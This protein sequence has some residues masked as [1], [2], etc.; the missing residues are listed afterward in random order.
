MFT[1]AITDFTP[2]G[3]DF[4]NN[5]S[6][7][8]FREGYSD[9]DVTM[10]TVARAL[11]SRRL[12]EEEKFN[13]SLFDVNYNKTDDI[14]DVVLLYTLRAGSQTPE[15]LKNKIL[16]LNLNT[17]GS[18]EAKEII[19]KFESEWI[20][21]HDTFK[22]HKKADAFLSNYLVC[23]VM[24]NEANRSAI[25]VTEK[26]NMPKWHV[27][28]SMIPAYVPD[29]FKGEFALTDEEK[30]MA[31][32]LTSRNVAS[33]LEKLSALEKNYNIR[34][35]RIQ[36][37]IGGFEKKQRQI[38]K[39]QIEET[40]EDLRNKMEN[41]IQRYNEL[42]QRYDD[43]N[44][45]RN[46]L[47]Y[48]IDNM[49]DN[50]DLVKFFQAN[51]CLDVV[52]TYGSSISFI[53]RTYYENFDVD[54]YENYRNNDNFLSESRPRTGVFTE[55]ENRK[56]IMDAMFITQQIKLKICAL[57]EL[58]IRGRL[59]TTTSYSFPT[60]CEDYI[61]NYHI[62]HHHCFGNYER[63]ILGYLNRGDTIGAINACIASAKSVNIAESGPTFNPMMAQ[64][65]ASQKKCFEL[66]DGSSVT[67][68]GALKY[69]N[70]QEEN[71]E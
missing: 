57:Y 44:L 67:P 56:K 33:F 17:W 40:L 60:N 43:Q 39:E 41:A 15:D 1:R 21:Q 9:H 19:Q 20:P 50:D 47:I 64:V 28:S 23:K 52:S 49:D 7:P 46:G 65:F 2:W 51:K 11:L 32:A 12:K 34:E 22:I 58:D 36:S 55:K 66:P 27:L 70:E 62:N 45:V 18:E 8:L 37:I 26:L 53:V 48:M 54:V 24:I 59:S 3:E 5:I 71:K 16:I 68:E 29:L 13:I 10:S 42:C 4:F 25:I 69:L 35:K 14:N 30:I 63:V 38:Q 61:P 31:Q 6:A